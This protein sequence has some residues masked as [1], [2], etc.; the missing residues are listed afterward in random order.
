[1]Y[2]PNRECPDAKEF[3]VAGEYTDRLTVCPKCGVQLVPSPPEAIPETAVSEIEPLSVCLTVT[4]ASLLPH[5][6]AVLDAAGVRYLVKN[7]GVQHLFGWGT[8]VFGFNPITGPPVVMVETSEL[9]RARALLREFSGVD[10]ERETA[11]AALRPDV[12]R[13]P[14]V[15][16]HCQ[17]PL[18][19]EGG[20]VPLTHCYHCGWPVPSA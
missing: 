10:Q 12:D 18:E 15:C 4:D 13:Q 2:C 6:K 16:G 3:G 1:M 17:G 8:A 19:A 14:A 7:E 9:D 5:I 11:P 20:D